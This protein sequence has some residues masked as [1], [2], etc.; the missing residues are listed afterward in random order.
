VVR[1]RDPFTRTI[2]PGRKMFC[3]IEKVQHPSDNYISKYRD[4]K[5]D[6]QELNKFIFELNSFMGI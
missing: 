2:Q 1:L 4:I 6:D 3:D 5:S